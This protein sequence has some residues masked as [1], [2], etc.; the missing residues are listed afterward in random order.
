MERKRSKAP[1]QTKVEKDLMFA[2]IHY[3][4]DNYRPYKEKG[5]WIPRLVINEHLRENHFVADEL[6]EHFK[7]EKK[8]NML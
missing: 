7:I 5:I 3:L 4:H 2:F 1:I 8:I 6:F